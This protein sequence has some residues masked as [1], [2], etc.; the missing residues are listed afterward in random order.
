MTLVQK[1]IQNIYYWVEPPTQWVLYDETVASSSTWWS[2]WVIANVN[3]KIIRPSYTFGGWNWNYSISTRTVG[4]TTYNVFQA[5]A[6]HWNL[7]IGLSQADFDDWISHDRVK[8]VIDYMYVAPASSYWDSVWLNGS[9]SLNWWK[10]EFSSWSK[11]TTWLWNTYEASTPYSAEYIIDTSTFNTEFTLT[12]L[13]NSST[14]T[15]NFTWTP[16]KETNSTYIINWWW[17]VIWMVVTDYTLWAVRWWMWDVHLY[18][19]G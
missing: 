16:W 5:S 10:M 13:N 11:V 3:W 15:W 12:N 4:S 18:Y 1:E 9:S 8:V 7:H 17:P 19:E 2:S 14:I 6:W